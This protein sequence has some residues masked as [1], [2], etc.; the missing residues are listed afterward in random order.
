MRKLT[1]LMVLA[2][3]TA[4]FADQPNVAAQPDSEYASMPVRNIA[5]PDTNI[6]PNA[7]GLDLMIGNSG[8]GLGFSYIH[9]LNSTLSWTLNLTASEAK[10]PNE[11]DYIDP[12]TG[13]KF[14][15][16]KINQLFVFPAMIG[17]QYR[18]FKDQ[19]T[20]SFRPYI[21]AGLGPNAV[22]AA[23][24]NQPLGYS[25]S[26]GK[27]YFGMGAYFGAGAYF[28]LDPHSLMGVSLRY[29]V[30]PMSHGIESMQ[31]EPMANFNT[32][33]IAFNIATQY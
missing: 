16:G 15:P 4:A 10:A 3:A 5:Q 12:F 14:V 25:F 19:I 8:F 7:L 29:Y 17:L 20:D 11:I 27:G 13:Q 28:G 26:H 21:F 24:Y 22:F 6:K 9:A 2:L 30:L 1:I 32:F 23:P 33:F 18:L 31:N